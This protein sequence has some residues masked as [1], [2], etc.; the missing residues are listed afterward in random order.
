MPKAHGA[1]AGDDTHYETLNNKNRA[2]RCAMINA[3]RIGHVVLKVRDLQRSR[4][5][6]TE[7]LGMEVMKE[8]SQ[9]PIVFLANN[10]RDHHEVGLL[11]VGSQA[12]APR[13][14]D[15]GLLHVAFRLRNESDL[16][17]AYKVLKDNDVPISFTVNH[18]ITKS[19]YFRDPDGHE[20]EVYCDNPPEEFAKMTNSYMGMDKLDFAPNDPGL[21]DAMSAQMEQH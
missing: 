12:E 2:R 15:I 10:R 3:E 11:Q 21:A 18:G 8:I 4:K 17:A 14:N 19:I 16:R 20:L 9:P 7:V 6:Y 5:F 1:G 13:A